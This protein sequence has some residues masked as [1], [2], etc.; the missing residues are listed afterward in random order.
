MGRA[1]KMRTICLVLSTNA[2]PFKIVSRAPSGTPSPGLI[3]LLTGSRRTATG[4]GTRRGRSAA[5]VK[6]SAC[7]P[8]DDE[9]Q[10]SIPRIPATRSQHNLDT[11]QAAHSKN[12]SYWFKA[13]LPEGLCVGMC[14][15]TLG[16]LTSPHDDGMQLLHPDEYMW[17]QA[18]FKSSNSRNSY[19]MGRAALRSSLESLIVDQLG[20]EPELQR[21]RS[22]VRSEPFNKDSFGRPIL[23]VGVMG[24]I[25][26]KNDYAVGLSSMRPNVNVS[27]EVSWLADCPVLD[28]ED[29]SC[30]ADIA[31]NSNRQTRG[32]GI[33]LERINDD[34]GSRIQHKVLTEWELS[35]LGGLE[36]IGISKAQEVM[37]RF[38]L[39]ES[40]YKAMHPIICEYVSFKEAETTPFTDGMAKVE[41]SLKSGL[42]QISINASWRVVDE[43]FLTSAAASM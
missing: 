8:R 11:G 22:A 3:K 16:S 41:L 26:H 40:A 30:T 37:L 42:S 39:K 4:T 24:S 43:F 7:F 14:K 36:S 31:G 34:R 21:L 5:T 23:P 15:S 29:E 12:G 20:C 17:G 28:T 32:I 10:T 18:N 19:Y 25:S 6:L 38:S 2:F 33:D 13:V 1:L 27:D 35:H 9:G